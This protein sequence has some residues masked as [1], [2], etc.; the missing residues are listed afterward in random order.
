[1]KTSHSSTSA[2]HLNIVGHNVSWWLVILI[3]VLMPVSSNSQ[4]A[5][6]QVP[7][8]VAPAGLS[9]LGSVAITNSLTLEFGLRL[10]NQDKLNSLIQGLYDTNSPLY[11]QYLTKE[12]FVEAFYPSPEDYQAVTDFA[13]K[14]GF[15]VIDKASDS[16]LIHVSASV[17]D[18]ERVFNVK[19]GR[20]QHPSE[21][22]IFYAPDVEPSIPADLPIQTIWGLTSYPQAYSHTVPCSTE[23]SLALAN[24]GHGI[25]GSYFGSDFRA[26]YAPNVWLTGT[27]QTVGLMEFDGY[28]ASD[29]AQYESQAGLPAVPLVNKLYDG[30]QGLQLHDKNDTEVPLDIDLVVSMAPGLSQVVVFEGLD[31]APYFLPNDVFSAMVN[32]TPKINQLCSCWSWQTGPNFTFDNLLQQAIAQGQSVFIASGDSDGFWSVAPNYVDT[33]GPDTTPLDNPWATMVGG[34]SLTTGAAGQWTGEAVWNRCTNSQ[35]SSGGY[36]SGY[37]PIPSWQQ[38]INMSQNLGSTTTRNS[39]DVAMVAENVD[40]ILNSTHQAVGGTSCAAPLWAGIAALANQRQASAALPPIGFINPA[41]YAY[42][43][44]GMYP[45]AFHDITVGNSMPGCTGLPAYFDAYPGYD[46]CTGWGTPTGWPTIAWAL[47]PNCVSPPS[48]L[49]G[50]WRGEGTV[51]DDSGHNNTGIAQGGLGY[52]AGFVG[53]AFEMNGVDADVMVPNSSGNLDVG[54]SSGFTI[55]AWISANDNSARPIVEWNNGSAFGVHL[56]ADFMGALFANVVDT[57]GA[58]HILSTSSGLFPTG[59]PQHVALTYDKA[60]GNMIIYLNGAVVAHQYIGS[61]VPQTSYDLYLGAR[62]N[63]TPDCRWNGVLDEVSVYN[64]ALT[65][66]EVEN[67]YA[68]G[69]QGKCCPSCSWL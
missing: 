23:S 3:A 53:Y 56:W 1:M 9:S 10:R 8:S 44:S 12:Q 47:S 17:A 49:V 54:Q 27:G 7:G 63:C 50:W 32:Y 6:K 16:L 35:G 15:T 65:S 30:S 21:P 19:M 52:G 61:V 48:G 59:A 14:S 13:T 51:G 46:L 20:Y 11:R 43:K 66:K 5:F 18:I 45:F 55:D 38:G 34:T 33:A 69:Q 36:S 28:L 4:P 39:P 60:S 22:R 62:V 37:Y 24:V 57:T 41:I 64:R 42:G 68:A 31:Y 58:N 2:T 25:N 29:V 26:A 67:I 40:V